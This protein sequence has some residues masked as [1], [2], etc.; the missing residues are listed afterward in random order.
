MINPDRFVLDRRQSPVLHLQA[1]V[2]VFA[3]HTASPADLIEG[4]PTEQGETWEIV[5]T[6]GCLIAPASGR[7]NQLRTCP[8]KHAART[9]ALAPAAMPFEGPRDLAWP[10]QLRAAEPDDV[11]TE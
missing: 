8:L 6:P 10:E 1:K 9:S 7:M 5:T 3:A 4:P 2:I 11:T